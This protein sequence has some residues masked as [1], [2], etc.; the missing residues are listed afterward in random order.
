MGF[1]TEL[2]HGKA[3]PVNP[4]GEILPPVS[5]VA[6]FRY[7]SMEDLERVFSHKKMGYAYTRI[8]NPTLS[9]FE[10]R[11]ASLEGSADA[12][13]CSSGMSAIT[14]ALLAICESGDEIIAGSGLYGGTI[15]LLRDL[16]KLGIHTVFAGELTGAAVA[17]RI[18]GKTRAVFGELISNPSLRVLDIPEVAGAVHEAGIPLL[19]DA[20]TATPYLARPIALGADIVIHSTSKYINGGGNAIGGI[21]ADSGR[22]A[23]DF[24][25]HAALS[26]FKKYGKGAFSVRLRTDIWENFG[27]CLSPVN[28]FLNY[29]GL[30][31]LGLRM[32]RICDNADRL[33][34][35]LDAIHGIE[36]NYLTLENHPYHAY[37]KKELNGKG[38][39]VLTFR[40]GTKERAFRIINALKYALIASNIGDLRTLVIHPASTLYLHS[41]KEEREEAGVYED[42]VRVSV[43]IEDPE[44]LIAD[45]TEAIQ[46]ADREQN[47]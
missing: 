25:K 44:D 11:I 34:H 35:A 40:A 38:G 24:E 36:V 47:G 12:V 1:H 39:G 13:C 21:V 8:G 17:E 28:A 45:F 3:I 29:I 4:G 20:T 30:D 27:G 10:R 26:E 33:A 43:G 42:T 22:F 15:D 5:Q 9:A 37:V 31:T 19:V 2:L 23:W 46:N 7:E 32:E 6:A 18:T 14:A 16:E 41:T